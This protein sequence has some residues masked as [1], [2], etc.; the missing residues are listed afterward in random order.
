M[1]AQVAVLVALTIA[2]ISASL[3]WAQFS[4]SPGEFTVSNVPPLGRAYSI[5]KK[6]VI[7]N[8]DNTK[9]VFVLSVEAPSAENL[10]EGYE[11]IPDPSW[12]ILMPAVVEIEGNSS[13]TV[14]ILL[15][16]PR[17][18]NLTNRKWEAWISVKRQ[19]V[20]GEM[21][22]MEIIS[23][24]RIETASELPP[25]ERPYSLL[26][27]IALVAGSAVVALVL[28]SL[29]RRRRVRKRPTLLRAPSYVATP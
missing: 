26:A 27:A 18:E 25:P 20:P 1:R 17:E 15:N 7:R 19:E 11:A 9:R 6:L 8:E 24:A 29:A 21:V 5:E 10:A 4:V 22:A 28:G 3:A 23:I 16:I 14:D 12:V 13:G 2:L